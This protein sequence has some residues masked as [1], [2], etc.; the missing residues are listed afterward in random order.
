MPLRENLLRAKRSVREYHQEQAFGVI[1]TKETDGV[2][3][4]IAI[5]T[6]ILD[7]QQTMWFF[8]LA[9]SNQEELLVRATA[10]GAH[11]RKYRSVVTEFLQLR[12]E[13]RSAVEK[14]DDYEHAL[15][16]GQIDREFE[17]LLSIPEDPTEWRT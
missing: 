10:L 11:I 2:Q 1:V 8:R 9:T 3:E 4:R 15:A 13:A 12:P 6:T 17:E 5:V 7:E 16:T 14:L